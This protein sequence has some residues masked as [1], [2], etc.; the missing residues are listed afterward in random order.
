MKN[1][2]LKII[3][4]LSSFALLLAGCKPAQNPSDSENDSI[5][6]PSFEPEKYESNGVDIS[7]YKI[8]IPKL[9]N[10]VTTYAS[11]ELQSYIKKGTGH[12]LDIIND[13]AQDDEYEIILGQCDREE[14]NDIDFEKLGD[15]SYIVKNVG[16]KLA[17]AANHKR[18]LLYGVYSFLEALGYRY[19][20]PTYE[21]IPEAEDIF[22]PKSINLSWEPELYYRETM[23]ANAWD[24]SF[25]VKSKIN[26]DFQRS[27][28]KNDLKYGGFSGYI[29]GG[30]Y[31]VHT[32]KYLLPYDK[33]HSEHPDWY[34]QKVGGMT[35]ATYLQPCFSNY[36]SIDTV[37]RTVDSLIASDPNANI[38]SISQNDGGEFCKC[39]NCTALK[40]LYG[41]SGVLLL[42]I[43]KI[44]RQIKDKYPNIKVD[45]LAYDWS[46]VAPKGGVKAEDNVTIRFCTEMCPFHDEEHKCEKMTSKEQYFIDWQDYASEFTV[47]TYPVGVENYYN[48]WPNYYELKDNNEFYV[49]HGV[50]GLYQEGYHRET[51]EFAE[52]KTY[53]LSKLAVNPRMSDEEYE[54]H[55]CDFLKG[56]YGSGWKHIREYIKASHDAIVDTNNKYGCFTTHAAVDSL[57]GRKCSS[58][59]YDE[60]FIT[61][62]KKYWDDALDAADD[63]IIFSHVE[64]SSLHW[65][66][67]EFYCT[68]KTRYL[69]ADLDE[70][71]EL[72]ERNK[73]LYENLKKYG[74]I[75]IYSEKMIDQNV[76]NF[77]HSPSTWG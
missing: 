45:T 62:M 33:Y 9:T 26:S 56:Y 52:L 65:T 16:K 43:N 13:T 72:K 12:T 29:G 48:S 21:K 66:Y 10:Y 50:K 58:T 40:E 14:I 59:T 11:S 31:L 4:L 60:A 18:G 20:T 23:F 32:F 75:Y 76:T 73:K 19:Y 30:K 25:A 39:D 37:M 27:E 47:W 53:V 8:V 5:S 17:I 64:K 55:I 22:I 46:Q 35:G 38:I 54:Y 71:S 42:Y 69:A 49:N 74:A 57:Y 28:L 61:Q 1:K 51:C 15:E 44:A 63:E 6:E 34:A 2:Q 3:L 41:E 67:I 70:A 24:A 7:S 36:E 68:F 77:S